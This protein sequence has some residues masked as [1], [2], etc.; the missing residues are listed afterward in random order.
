MLIKK[1]RQFLYLK[2]IYLLSNSKLVPESRECLRN[3]FKQLLN[4]IKQGLVYE[5]DSFCQEES[6]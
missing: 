3:V 2:L 1:G 5:I 4:K 6:V